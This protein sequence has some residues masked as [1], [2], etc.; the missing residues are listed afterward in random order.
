MENLFLCFQG[1]GPYWKDLVYVP[2]YPAGFSYA[3]WAFRYDQG[4][5]VSPDLTAEVRP[6]QQQAVRM[7]GVLAARFY[8]SR[9]ELILPL[10][11]IEV[12]WIDL[13]GGITQ[14][15]FRVQAL[16]D[17]TK[18]DSL[19]QACL[20]LPTAEVAET[21]Q[22][23]NA[24]AFRS[25]I[26]ITSLPWSPP[27]AEDQS[28]ARM[29]ELIWTNTS[30]PLREEVRSAT[31]VRLSNFFDTKRRIVVPKELETSQGQ[32]PV[33]G[34]QLKEGSQYHVNLTHRIFDD[35]HSGTAPILPIRFDLPSAS[36]QLTEPSLEVLG[37]YQ[38]TPIVFRALRA[39]QSHQVL[40]VRSEKPNGQRKSGQPDSSD[41]ALDVNLPIPF[42]VKASWL[43]RLRTRWA[44][45]AGLAVVLTIQAS[46]AY[47][48]DFFDKLLE[49]KASLADLV[50]YWPIILL[51]LFLGG[52]ASILV[53]FLSGQTKAPDQ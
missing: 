35:E 8:E 14:F 44:L 19:E 48:K 16:L 33:Y 36:L 29:L 9:R 26:D 20:R 5:W 37:W 52:V 42:L 27:D 46:I 17:F 28:W 11:K 4:R 15:Y 10:R 3:K 38:I 49:G 6:Q 23:R 43:Y 39:D 21:S 2:A 18:F 7:A 31:Y 1:D 53:T 51:L 34:V 50:H 45:R 41:R 40:I 13:T 32:G 25:K 22:N 30:V 12:T 24:L 47:F